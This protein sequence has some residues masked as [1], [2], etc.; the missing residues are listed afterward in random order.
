MRLTVTGL[1]LSGFK[2]ATK[3]AA[4]NLLQQQ[5]RSTR[6]VEQ[7][8]LAQGPVDRAW[9]KRVASAAPI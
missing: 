8:N 1:H 4:A 6:F 5:A 3:P 2:E 9:A 7:Y